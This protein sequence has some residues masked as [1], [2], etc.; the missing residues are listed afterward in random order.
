ME[1]EEEDE[2]EVDDWYRRGRV[3]ADRRKDAAAKLLAGVRALIVW[4]I[5]GCFNVNSGMERRFKVIAKG[6]ER[7][8]TPPT[9]SVQEAFVAL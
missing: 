6:N 5:F 9:F 7:V 1:E 2:A 3:V 8:V 4:M